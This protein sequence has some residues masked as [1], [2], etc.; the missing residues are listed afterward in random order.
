MNSA[1]SSKQIADRF[2]KYKLTR[3]V[4]A[5]F[6][7]LVYLVYLVW[8]LTI[9]A[10]H[11]FL[12]SF[13]YFI[14]EC[15]GFILSLTIIL[16]SWKYKHRESI[17]ASSGL[18]VDVF[19]LTYQEPI[20]VI[21]KTIQAAKNI[22]YPHQVRVLDDGRREEV[23]VLAQSIGVNYNSRPANTHA[24][25]GNLNFGLTLSNAEFIMVFDAD[26]IALPHALDVTLGYFIDQ[27]VGMVQ[28]PQDYYNT[29]AFQYINFKNNKIWHD[30][31][32]F[33]NISQSCQDSYNSST[34]V[35]T[36]VV[37]RRS[38][39]NAIGDF[40]TLT[41]TEDIHTSL[42][43]NK[44]GY[45]TVYLNETI[46]YG[47]AAS[48]LTEYYKTRHRW[49]HGNLHTL[50]HEK[51]LTC[52]GLSL[53]QRISYLSL[54][55][56][57]LEGWQKLFLFLIPVI[58]LIFGIP[59]FEISIFN[60]LVVLIFPVFSYIMLQEIG[61]G[62]SNFW[63]N[64][65][66]AIVRWPIHIVSTAGLFGK[67]IPWI[68]SSKK[69]K[70][71]VNW[72]FMSPQLS[73]LVISIASIVIAFINLKSNYQAGPIFSFFKNYIQPAVQLP[74]QSLAVN[75]GETSLI[76]KS[77]EIL[78]IYN[79]IDKGYSIDLVLI[80]GIWVLYSIVKIIF[81]IFKVFYNVK[82]STNYFQFKIPF[83]L[84]INGIDNAEVVKISEATLVFKT[85]QSSHSISKKNE[86]N[87]VLLYLPNSSIKFNIEI[88]N[89]SVK[90]RSQLT[91]FEAKIL[92]SS[93]S[94]R[95][96]LNN[97]IYSV[98]WHRSLFNHGT[99]SSFSTLSSFLYRLFTFKLSRN[100][101]FEQWAAVNYKLII[102]KVESNKIAFISKVNNKPGIATLVTFEK[103]K[104]D[105]EILFNSSMDL[106][107]NQSF[108]NIEVLKEETLAFSNRMC[109]DKS[110]MRRYT[111][112]YK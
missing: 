101:K 81:F 37:Y 13:F 27:K 8:R 15:F 70:S 87:N 111:V 38:A 92:W 30:Q 19:I 12:L 2:E 36:G 42:K 60:I 89:I 103:L 57:Y 48:D 94:E 1:S 31:S 72:L 3:R 10:Q 45:K 107:K 52:K 16:N 80:A 106:A 47:I 76:A 63:A 86:I 112:R 69:I 24:K 105:E 59:P 23:R 28:T 84:I 46:A 54:G 93:E 77:P 109:L 85:N 110:V 83:P 40:P 5:V 35:G 49:A 51:V 100:T 56:I 25:A 44:A 55:L 88:T 79:V 41:V 66:F 75:T 4:L 62:F 95:E 50:K 90:K 67:K 11:S 58:T 26:H 6:Y 32:F 61:C 91:V 20:E 104:I 39:I 71:E 17:I 29:D 78:N 99:N 98:N 82:N 64:E 33:Y 18:E 96:L 7:L 22:N 102:N 14:A 65:I 97:C 73:I 34:C 108:N 21:K 9:F 43:M 74:V 53:Q 68:S